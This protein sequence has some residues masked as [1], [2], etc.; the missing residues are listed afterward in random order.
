MFLNL[1]FTKIN[2]IYFDTPYICFLYCLSNSK[3][4]NYFLENYKDFLCG[5]LVERVT[6]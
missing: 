4:T 3:M 5:K 2:D 6:D 1:F